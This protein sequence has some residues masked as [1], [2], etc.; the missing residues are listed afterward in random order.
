[1]ADRIDERTNSAA[2]SRIVEFLAKLARNR[3]AKVLAD[4]AA[5]EAKAQVTRLNG[6]RTALFTQAEDEGVDKRA[7]KIADEWM[8]DDVEEM[9]RLLENVFFIL[10]SADVPVWREPDAQRPQGDLWASPEERQQKIDDMEAATAE[11]EGCVA[12]LEGVDID[13]NPHPVSSLKFASWAKGHATGTAERKKPTIGVGKPP[14]TASAAKK[15]G[16]PAK[17]AAEPKTEAAPETTK[18]A[19]GAKPPRKPPTRKAD[20]IGKTVGTAEPAAMAVGGNLTID[21]SARRLGWAVDGAYDAI[22]LP[23]MSSLGELYGGVRN[24]LCD[25]FEAY[26]PRRLIWCAAEFVEHETVWEAHKA[27]RTIAELAAHDN[28]VKPQVANQRQARIAVLGRGDF[29]IYDPSG[30][31]FIAEGGRKLAKE[32]VAAWCWAEGYGAVEFEVG[33]A[34]VLRRYCEIIGRKHDRIHRGVAARPSAEDAPRP[35]A[36]A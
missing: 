5:K 24:A 13:S 12:G 36:A 16:R 22:Q 31:G 20:T 15:P 10:R 21:I 27:T 8:Q 3:Q 9:N 25:L 6:E 1:M 30:L 14:K 32:T 23:G 4:A 19:A 29:G 17:A 26:Q 28:S 33:N 7:L 11:G 35:P 34:L 18:P 2:P